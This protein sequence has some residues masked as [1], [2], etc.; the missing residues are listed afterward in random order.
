M[1]SISNIRRMIQERCFADREFLRDLRRYNEQ[2]VKQEDRRLDTLTK[3]ELI[4]TSK[5]RRRGCDSRMRISEQTVRE[6]KSRGILKKVYQREAVGKR[7]CSNRG[8]EM[9]LRGVK[10]PIGLL[11]IQHTKK[12][13]T[14][15]ILVPTEYLKDLSTLY[16]AKSSDDNDYRIFGIKETARKNM[17]EQV[18]LNIYEGKN[19]DA[20]P[21]EQS[22]KEVIHHEN[23]RF[24]VLPECLRK[25]TAQEHQQYHRI[26]RHI[27]HGYSIWIESVEDFENIMEILEQ[28][29]QHCR[30]IREFG[31]Y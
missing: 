24:M 17:L 11:E 23:L 7:V 25:M 18:I 4:W 10:Q 6:L 9:Y 5:K 2:A 1:N 12:P 28:R 30:K 22:E 20:E 8:Y 16:F 19:V 21:I 3:D 26:A 14:I 31:L 27:S 13:D 15:W 29:I